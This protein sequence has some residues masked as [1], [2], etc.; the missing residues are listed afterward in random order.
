MQGVEGGPVKIGYTGN[1]AIRHRQL[2]K[3]YGRD[4]VILTTIPGGLNEEA[5]IHTQFAH[6]R[7]KG[8]GRRG[9][10]I[11]QFR[12]AVDLM[13]FVGRSLL[14]GL[15]PDAVE[16]VEPICVPKT[17]SVKLPIDVIEMAR[18]VAACRNETMTDLLGNTLRP[19]L[20]KMQREEFAKQTKAPKGK[21]EAK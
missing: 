8:K 9:R 12:P 3:R 15:N 1:L 14:V 16:L 2:E 19:L 21:G 11:E 7:L 5:E 17:L 4:L 18:I 13:E 10:R 6:L 20:E